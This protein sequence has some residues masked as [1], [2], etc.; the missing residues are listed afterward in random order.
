MNHFHAFAA[1]SSVFKQALR[2]ADE[3]TSTS[4]RT[5]LG[6]I[7]SIYPIK[8]L[9]TKV[10]GIASC[11]DTFVILFEI[12]QRWPEAVMHSRG[13]YFVHVPNVVRSYGD[14]IGGGVI[15]G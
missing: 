4:R 3:L 8:K 6:R 9:G 1:N 5:Y 12:D 13:N 10:E 7:C 11:F 2:N 14:P 15:Y